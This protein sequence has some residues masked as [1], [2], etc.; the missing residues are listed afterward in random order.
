M[1]NPGD[2]HWSNTS[3]CGVAITADTR[4]AR[5][6]P[7]I[8][9]CWSPNT[10]R[11]S[12]SLSPEYPERSRGGRHSTVPSVGASGLLFSNCFRRFRLKS[13]IARTRSSSCV[14]SGSTCKRLRSDIETPFGDFETS[15]T[16]SFR[17]RP[18]S[19]STEQ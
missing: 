3:K 8:G 10:K 6:R 18:P 5:S 2:S 19:R 4:P 1:A 11:S 14:F 12:A 7:T 13:E 16:G 15:R 9:G 17:L